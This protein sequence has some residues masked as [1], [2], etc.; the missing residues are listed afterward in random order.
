M[1]IR[2][3][4]RQCPLVDGPPKRE[5]LAEVPVDC[6]RLRGLHCRSRIPQIVQ[7]SEEEEQDDDDNCVEERSK[8]V[9]ES[10]ESFSSHSRTETLWYDFDFGR[11]SWIML[12]EE[13]TN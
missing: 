4:P 3:A 5:S 13:R 10:F 8:M 12:P 2:T 6:P 7:Q 1:R 9:S 11:I